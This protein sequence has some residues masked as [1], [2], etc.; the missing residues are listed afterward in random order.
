MAGS[1]SLLSA[2]GPAQGSFLAVFIDVGC[3][4]LVFFDIVQ[5]VA[6]F[7]LFLLFAK[8]C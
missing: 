1:A 8:L 7:L 3:F 5:Y 6:A 4:S 2:L